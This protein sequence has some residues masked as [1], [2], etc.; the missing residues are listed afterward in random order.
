M[1]I[2][3][4][5]SGTGLHVLD[6]A[7]SL[8][9]HGVEGELHCSGT[10]LALG[11][12]GGG[13][14]D[15]F[16]SAPWDPRLRVCRT[17]DR[18]VMDA[19]GCLHFRG[20][21]DDQVKICGRRVNLQELRRALLRLDGVTEAV[22]AMEPDDTGNRLVARIETMHGKTHA[23]IR[24]DLGLLLPPHAIPERMGRAA[25]FDRITVADYV[26]DDIPRFVAFWHDRQTPH[27]SRMGV[28]QTRLPSAAAMA[29][30]LESALDRRDADPSGRPL[31]L[32][33]IRLDG[34]TVGFHQITDFNC[35]A[36]RA[37]MHAY[38]TD[39]GCRGC[40]IGTVSYAKALELLFLRFGL[41]EIVFDT[42][43]NNRAALRVKAALGIAP[44]GDTVIDRP[45]L[46]R[47]LRARRF[48]VSADQV[49][50]LLRR[51]ATRSSTAVSTVGVGEYRVPDRD[52]LLAGRGRQSRMAVL[53][54]A[55]KP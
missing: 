20:R 24:E 46:H 38:L 48:V 4:A 36:R 23:Q 29:E 8:V 2:G 41:D 3:R 32:V 52:Q 42:P 9:P 49:D 16:L 18:V 25:R 40:G 33:A 31:R 13:T 51:A 19:S 39:P 47:P 22:A 11:Y 12:L 54:Q 37:G 6:T 7:L 50:G 55:G 43:L 45:F 35:T 28:D 30:A 27:I 21:S 53:R 26:G 17:G 10:G 5:V 14:Q 15:A 44:I 34:R 1:P